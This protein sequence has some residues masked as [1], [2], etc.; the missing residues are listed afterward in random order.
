MSSYFPGSRASVCVPAALEDRQITHLL[1][2]KYLALSSLHSS[3]SSLL[4]N[5]VSEQI[6]YGI[7]SGQWI[8]CPGCVPW[9]DLASSSLLARGNVGETALML[10]RATQQQPKH[11]SVTDILLATNTKHSTVRNYRENYPTSAR[12]NRS[13]SFR[14]SLF[15]KSICSNYMFFH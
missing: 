3:F 4:L 12:L 10:W 6:C 15:F 9:Q 2:K 11:C 13:V 5:V 1:I 8:N 14:V 7:S